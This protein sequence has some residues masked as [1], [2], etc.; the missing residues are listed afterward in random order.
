MLQ[1]LDQVL[2]SSSLAF[3]LLGGY[4]CSADEAK[5]IINQINL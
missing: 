3:D 5:L 2:A 1:T 4:G